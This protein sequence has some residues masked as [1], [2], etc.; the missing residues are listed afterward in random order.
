[1]VKSPT[2][3]ETTRPIMRQFPVASREYT[4]IQDEYSWQNDHRTGTALCYTRPA[5]SLSLV[6]AR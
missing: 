5:W 4:V 2:D 6:L 3:V 1:M